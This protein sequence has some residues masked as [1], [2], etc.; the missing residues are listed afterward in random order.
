M[1]YHLNEVGRQFVLFRL[2][3]G[4]IRTKHDEDSVYRRLS[5][6]KR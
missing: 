4:F 2:E 1:L 3:F 6:G 5:D